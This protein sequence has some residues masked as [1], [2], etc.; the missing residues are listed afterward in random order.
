MSVAPVRSPGSRLFPAFSA[1]P[2][3][4]N[5]QIEE[6]S[7]TY[8]VVRA[9]DQRRLILAITYFIDKPF[10]NW[11]RSSSELLGTVFL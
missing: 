8:V 6:I 5:G 1:L 10:Q 3:V 2:T 9:W 4:R 7:L 11:T